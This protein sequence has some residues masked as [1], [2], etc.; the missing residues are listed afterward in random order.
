M[1]RKKIGKALSRYW[2]SPDGWRY[3]RLGATAWFV[4]VLV[5]LSVSSYLDAMDKMA[6][7]KHGIESARN[8]LAEFRAGLDM[9]SRRM[10]TVEKQI[11]DLERQSTQMSKD[12]KELYE[13]VVLRVNAKP[14]QP[15]SNMIK[16]RSKRMPPKAKAGS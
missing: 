8:D 11:D 16:V 6:D 1:N 9:L 10:W 7:V 14:P 4:A 15:N 3:I 2:P 5:W 13:L 12:I